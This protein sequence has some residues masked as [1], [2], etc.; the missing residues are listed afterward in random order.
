LYVSH[1][2]QESY[3][4]SIFENTRHEFTLEVWRETPI[5]NCS[6]IITKTIEHRDTVKK[7]R[8]WRLLKQ[9]IQIY[10]QL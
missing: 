6:F 3:I 2:H 5:N 9:K 1:I 4:P 10:S 7:L 8:E